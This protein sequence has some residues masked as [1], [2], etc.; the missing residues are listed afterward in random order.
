MDSPLTFSDHEIEEE[1]ARLG[2][3]NIPRDK[4]RDF[5]KDLNRLV[6]A[7]KSKASSNDNSFASGDHPVN[8]GALYGEYEI[9]SRGQDVSNSACRP[10][11]GDSHLHRLRKEDLDLHDKRQRQAILRQKGGVPGSFACYELPKATLQSQAIR[12]D[13]SETESEIRRMKRKTLR[14]NEEGAKFINESMSDAA[15]IVDTHRRMERLVLRDL[16]PVAQRRTQS[17]RSSRDPPPYRLNPDDPRPPS[18]IHPMTDHPHTKNLRRADP[19]K[20]HKQIQQ[21]WA[22]QQAPGEK[23]RKGLRWNV[24]QQMLTQFVPEKKPQRNYVPNKYVPPT[25]KMRY[26]LRWQLRL[27]MAEGSKPIN[28]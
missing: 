4:L 28:P 27:D 14:K 10:G 25:D 18:V 9:E 8:G 20:R 13:L 12:D 6:E 1:L 7:E 26:A 16:D 23:L 2:Y 24:K 11:A 19:V 15:S 22:T 3:Q 17:A 21:I 5:Q